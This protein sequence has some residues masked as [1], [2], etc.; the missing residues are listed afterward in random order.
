MSRRFP[1]KSKTHPNLVEPGANAL[2]RAADCLFHLIYPHRSVSDDAARPERRAGGWKCSKWRLR[3]GAGNRDSWMGES[4][5]SLSKTHPFR[6]VNG[7]KRSRIPNPGSR[8]RLL[9]IPQLRIER[10]PQPVADQ[11]DRED[12][13]HD[14]EA[15]DRCQPPCGREIRPPVSQHVSPRRSRRTDSKPEK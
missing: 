8:R 1:A 13:Q 6:E 15:G 7:V 4:E 11:V 12:R 9:D 2:K 5:C 10:V 3:S 14:R